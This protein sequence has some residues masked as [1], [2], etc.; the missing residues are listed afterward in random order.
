MA[1][2][3]VVVAQPSGGVLPCYV[4]ARQT[5]S[6]GRVLHGRRNRHKNDEGFFEFPRDQHRV[7]PR[8]PMSNMATL[9]E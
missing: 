4:S 1:R 5:P 8:V 3:V 7:P 9:M 2:P 6:P